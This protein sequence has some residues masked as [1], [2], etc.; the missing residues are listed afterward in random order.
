[1]RQAGTEDVVIVGAGIAGIATAYYLSIEMPGCRIALVDSLA[2]MSFMSAQ[3][4]ENYRNWWPHPLMT[5]FMDRSID[6]LDAI[7]GATGNRIAINRRGYAL[8][9]RQVSI[10]DM[11]RSLHAGY[12]TAA[13]SIR[14]HTRYADYE[15]SLKEFEEGVDIVS[16]KNVVQQAFPAFDKEVRHVIH[17]R[18]AGDFDSYQ[19]S[20][21][22]LRQIRASGGRLIQGE[23]VGIEGK[24][25]YHV[26]LQ[27]GSRMVAERLVVAAGPFVNRI[28]GFLGERIP[29]INALQQKFAFEDMLQAIPAEQPFSVDLDE[30]TLDWSYDE[31]GMLAEDERYRIFSGTLPG[32]VHRRI[33]G[34][35]G[36]RSLR[37]GW[38][39][40][41]TPVEPLWSPPLDDVFPEVVLRAAA[42][43][44]PGLRFYVDNMPAAS[45]HYGGY[46]TMTEENL[47]LIGPMQAPGLYVVGALSGF[48]TMAACAAG[49]SCAKW[50]A[51]SVLPPY[52]EALSPDRYKDP[53]L[54]QELMQQDDRGVL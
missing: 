31:R 42:Q 45:H 35:N 43:L 30:V 54:M 16:G 13:T 23:V 46:Y 53:R 52:A 3:S 40:Q 50:I 51:D 48:G 18:R 21:H 1:M 7:V 8:A 34:A 24:G 33:D 36:R 28:L 41:N 38:A 37:L 4:G 32:K 25:Y 27:D 9:T 17:I 2:P 12:R 47:P 49:E 29:V 6:L 20:Q 5:E 19:L 44:N 26:A 11:A 14:D 39:W 15:K 10:D 22:M